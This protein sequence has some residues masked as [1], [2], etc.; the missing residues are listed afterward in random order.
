MLDQS[1][2][3]QVK[4]LFANLN[5]QYTFQIKVAN[6]HSSKADLVGM[7]EDVASCSDKVNCEITEAE[8]LSFSIAKNG[9]P[10]QVVFR[11]VPTGHE[12]TTLLLAILNQE[13]IG[14]NLPDETTVARI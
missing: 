2:K 13:G 3:D 6:N 4:A 1:V 14:K 9:E 7:L 12:F 11:A 5:N 10:T 8:G